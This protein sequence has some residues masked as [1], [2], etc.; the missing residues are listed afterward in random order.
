MAFFGKLF[1]MG[2]KGVVEDA[3]KTAVK[4]AGR[5]A[6]EDAGRTVSKDAAKDAGK[7]AA[8]D[9]GKAMSTRGRLAMGATG[10]GALGLGGLGLAASQNV[11]K[12]KTCI[13]VCEGTADAHELKND[14]DDPRC[15]PHEDDCT[16]Y[17]TEQ[18][19]AKYPTTISGEVLHTL[20]STFPWL[21]GIIQFFETYGSD[22]L[23]GLGVLVG[24]IVLLKVIAF[25]RSLGRDVKDAFGSDENVSRG[26]VTRTRDGV[27]VLSRAAVVV[28]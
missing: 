24:L 17:C 16:K 1:S 21:K 7:D 6:A 3:G 26:V 2:A 22:I 11:A 9:A 14:P 20:E 18:C 19:K 28:T 4:D 23:I 13:S 15:P 12:Q 27:R 8:K 5:T 10:A 25:F